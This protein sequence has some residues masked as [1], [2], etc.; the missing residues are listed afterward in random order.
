MGES[1]GGADGASPMKISAAQRR[2]SLF[3]VKGCVVL[4]K[5]LKSEL[6]T[7]LFSRFSRRVTYDMFSRCGAY[8]YH[9]AQLTWFRDIQHSY[10]WTCLDYDN[11]SPAC[12]ALEHLFN[13]S[14]IRD[15]PFTAPPVM[16]DILNNKELLQSYIRSAYK[17]E[18]ERVTLEVFLEESEKILESCP[19]DQ[20]ASETKR[21][22]DMVALLRLNSNAEIPVRYVHDSLGSRKE[23]SPNALRV[24]RS[25]VFESALSL[26]YM[27]W[28]RMGSFN[29]VE[30]TCCSAAQRTETSCLTQLLESLVDTSPPAAEC[31]MKYGRPLLSGIRPTLQRATSSFRLVDSSGSSNAAE[32]G[33]CDASSANSSSSGSTNTAMNSVTSEVGNNPMSVGSQ[34]DLSPLDVPPLNIP[35]RRAKNNSNSNPIAATAET[36]VTPHPRVSDIISYMPRVP[37]LDETLDSILLRRM[38]EDYY[39]LPRL[40]D[41]GDRQLWKK[42]RDF[43]GSFTDLSDEEFTSKQP[44]LRAK[45]QEILDQF[46]SYLRKQPF[47]KSRLASNCI[48]TMRFFREEE[49]FLYGKA[50]QSYESLL[51]KSGWLKL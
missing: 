49:T 13:A 19:P 10:L 8:V 14:S 31:V 51:E 39:L 17:N 28:I 4:D 15:A 33:T 48:V 18:S 41:E 34:G 27:S 43:A 45:A 3:G 38:F 2:Q 21:M 7:N 11:T 42:L 1:L 25:L 44:E 26:G 22:V 37:S 12:Q 47:L 20:L 36:I 5:K 23:V 30:W 50:H 46:P 6:K 40:T 16:D 29:Q 32:Q 9:R 24:I 35:S